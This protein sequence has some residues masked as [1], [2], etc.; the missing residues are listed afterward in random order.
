MHSVI[1]AGNFRKTRQRRIAL[2]ATDDNTPKWKRWL[3]RF[4]W[5]GFLFFLIK[6][7]LW[8]LAGYWIFNEAKP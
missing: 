4:G 8:L 2:A 3:I 7:I 6:G 1:F 5:A